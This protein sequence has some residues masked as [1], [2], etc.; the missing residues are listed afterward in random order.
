MA[1]H[2]YRALV[3][4]DWN[5]CLAPC[6]PFD[7]LAFTHPECAGL[8]DRV[9]R[10]YTGNEISLGQA[11]NKVLSILPS[12]VSRAQMDAYLAERFAIYRGVA[13][14]MAWCEK[15]D[16]L[17][18][19]NTTG[20]VGYFQ[21][22]CH[23]GMI[24]PVPVLSASPQF[25]FPSEGDLFHRFL[26]LYEVEDKAAN[27]A[28]VLKQTGIAAERAVLIGDSGGDGPHFGWGAK[29]GATLVG[30]M[31]KPSLD[32]Y[33]RRGGIRIHHRIGKTYRPGETLDPKQEM[34]V[35]F[36]E[37]TEIVEAVLPF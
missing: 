16:V 31:T 6:G 27:T 2:R 9:F 37:L 24:P 22:A 10:Q 15:N 28:S 29:Q 34:A 20:A 23:A 8:L 1:T 11:V 35:D 33:C 19:I 4:S 12:P 18:M 13:E 26:P 5:Q 7:F 25:R 32:D 21:R 30:S 14:F 36:M 3:S 17:F